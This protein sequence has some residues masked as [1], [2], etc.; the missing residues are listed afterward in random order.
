MS[1]AMATPDSGAFCLSPR[2]NLWLFKGLGAG[3]ASNLRGLHIRLLCLS[4]VA[5]GA[6]CGFATKFTLKRHSSIPLVLSVAQQ[7]GIGG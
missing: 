1:K 6:H 5:D 3:C 2:F 7:V 4:D